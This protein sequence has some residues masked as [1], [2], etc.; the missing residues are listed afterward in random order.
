MDCSVNSLLR[1]AKCYC[2]PADSAKAIRLWLLCQWLKKNSSPVGP[3][4]NKPTTPSPVNANDH[5]GN[6]IVSGAGPILSWAN[7]GNTTS[8]NVWF[9][10][11][12]QG[13]QAGT[14]FALPALAYATGYSWRIDAV[15]ANGTTTGDTWTFTTAPRF[16]WTLHTAVLDWHDSNGNHSTDWTTFNATADF[17]SVDAVITAGNPLQTLVG[18]Q[19]LPSLS[20]LIVNSGTIP[21]VDIRDCS[22]L[23]NV[24][25][26]D[27]N[28]TTLNLQGC[29]NITTL[30]CGN[31]AISTLDFTQC[32]LLSS[33]ECSFSN[34][35]PVVDLSVCP[36]LTSVNV[37]TAAITTL[38]V[39]G[40]SVLS[41][42]V[43]SSNAGLNNIVGIPDL[44]SLNFF[45]CSGCRLA[46]LDLTASPALGTFYCGSQ[47]LASLVSV[48][49]TNL[50]SL[51]DFNCA[52]NSITALDVTGCSMIGAT[53]LDC[54]LNNIP[55]LGAG[56]INDILVKTDNFAIANA[57]SFGTFASNNQ[58]PAAPPSG[59][60]A[61]AATDLGTT[62]NWTVTTD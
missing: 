34:L 61:A 47:V 51:T 62:W 20:T 23:S 27:N 24:N 29:H 36:L 16:E 35:G 46:A 56:G 10:G 55:T 19:S 14:T 50:A 32:P 60:G 17:K 6:I 30:G 15:N 25:V 12:F 11:V 9:N 28:L 18:V 26:G 48:T 22:N 45:L 8:Y 31:N 39:S 42:L 33:F 52:A 40:C 7:G 3:L 57:T 53:G 41:S 59:A 13:N 2:F 54:S 44:V 37:D 43:C 5:V 1:A 58:T 49:I 21:A 38:I 4:P